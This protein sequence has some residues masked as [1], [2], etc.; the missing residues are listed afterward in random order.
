MTMIDKLL[1]A[2]RGEIAR[3]VFR[4]CRALG[5]DTVAV[6]SDADADAPHVAEADTAVRLPGVAPADTYLRPDLLVKAATEAG[7]DAVHPGYGF[8]SE[9]AGFARTVADAG[10]TWVGPPPDAIEAM[11]SKVRAKRLM[12]DAGVPVL[13]ELTVDEVTEADL[14][15]LVK[16]SAGGGGRGMRVVRS[17]R[18]L[19]DAVASA[20]EEARA[21]FGDPTVFCERYLEAGR[22]IEVQVLADEH[23]TV[24]ALG[25]RECSIQRRHQKVIEE[26]PSPLVDDAM[27]VRLGGAAVAAARAV[28]YVGA[29]T[30]EFLASSDGEFFFLEMNTRLQV[31]HP[32]TEC[33]TGVDLVALQLAVAEGEPLSPDGPPTFTGHAIEARL[34]AEDPARDWRPQS[35]RLHRFAVPGVTAEFT[36]PASYGLRLDSGVVDGSVV[37][38]HYDPM[39]AKVIAWAPTR[40]AAARALAGALARARIHGVRTNRDLLVRTLRHPAFL[41]GETDTA[42]FDRH[43][44]AA[45]AAPL[46]GPDAVRL[47]ALAAALAGEAANRAVAPVLR[48][49]PSGWR[50]VAAEPQRKRLVVSDDGEREVEV[51]YRLT[52]DGSGVSATVD[53]VGLDAVS[54]LASAPNRVELE[55]AGVRRRFEVSRYGSVPAGGLAE[56]VAVES[57]LGSVSFTPVPRFREPGSALA[58][59]SLVAPMPGTVLRL[60]VA[61]GERVRAGQPVLW[62]EAMKMEHQITAPA[63]GVLAELP[64]G[65]GQQVEV[66]TL[67]AVVS[68]RDEPTDTA[69]VTDTQPTTD[70][71]PPT[72]SVGT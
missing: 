67:L 71:A 17:L 56:L 15:V 52:R 25:E 20:S 63:D 53:G 2:N 34:Y 49:L 65:V 23:G 12:A 31:E 48:R 30:V 19:P 22:H 9:N 32:V 5:V 37:G 42:F 24:W 41:A 40:T 29:G 58:A 70:T 36:V 28:G 64:V 47:S 4:S 69:S 1:M 61:V 11:G 21:A 26:A 38:T 3:R 43:G 16:A 55:V 57:S 10:L 8:L 6:Y 18:A 51:A 54:V 46:A 50:N 13:P 68:A 14:P 45:L 7:A 72:D 35:G 59:G 39:L 27:R 44:L 66:G 33:V 60:G 62:L